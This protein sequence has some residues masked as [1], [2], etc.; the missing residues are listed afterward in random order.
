MFT[1]VSIAHKQL[2]ELWPNAG[3]QTGGGMRSKSVTHVYNPFQELSRDLKRLG[4]KSNLLG[5]DEYRCF[6]VAEGHGVR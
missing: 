5:Q 2:A 6:G 1:F 4:W 3:G